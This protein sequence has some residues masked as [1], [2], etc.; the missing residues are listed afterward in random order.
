MIYKVEGFNAIKHT[1]T[2][3]QQADY[4]SPPVETP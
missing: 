1:L 3:Q 2:K 4:W